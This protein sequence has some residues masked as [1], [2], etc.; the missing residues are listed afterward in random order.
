[1]H[2]LLFILCLF[3]LA[4]PLQAQPIWF[5]VSYYPPINYLPILYPVNYVDASFTNQ[6][7]QAQTYFQLDPVND[8]VLNVPPACVN[9]FP[10]PIPTDQAGHCFSWCTQYVIPN[11]LAAQNITQLFCQTIDSDFTRTYQQLSASHPSQPEFMYMNCSSLDV[12]WQ[13]AKPPT[14]DPY[15]LD[16]ASSSALLTFTS[17]VCMSSETCFHSQGLPKSPWDGPSLAL[18]QT[19]T[20][21]YCCRT[22]QQTDTTGSGSTFYSASYDYTCVAVLYD[23]LIPTAPRAQV[24]CS[25]HIQVDSNPINSSPPGSDHL[26]LQWSQTEFN[27]IVECV[28]PYYTASINFQNYDP[29]PTTIGCSPDDFV[30]LCTLNVNAATG[31]LCTNAGEQLQ[32]LYHYTQTQTYLAGF[33]PSGLFYQLS[34]GVPAPTLPIQYLFYSLTWTPCVVGQLGCTAYCHCFNGCPDHSQCNQHGELWESP[35]L[36]I[37]TTCQCDPGWAGD[38]CLYQDGN[39]LCGCSARTSVSLDHSYRV[40]RLV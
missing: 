35:S 13:N 18:E 32:G 7:F 15:S 17:P 36:G 19:G 38:T 27:C 20:T 24:T 1:M 30:D 5:Q 37:K 23:T 22:S 21:F 25:R 29:Q 28:H 26:L 16:Q 31:T 4:S 34:A 9:L 3:F 39:Q 33:G 2:V 40:P 11:S 8:A 14:Y 12:G 6:L 10:N